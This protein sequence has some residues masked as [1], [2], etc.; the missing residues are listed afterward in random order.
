MHANDMKSIASDNYAVHG[1]RR[2][3]C[4]EPAKA[5]SGNEKFAG[6]VPVGMEN[7]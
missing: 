3:A 1:A 6:P 7:G 4:A 5:D 2:V